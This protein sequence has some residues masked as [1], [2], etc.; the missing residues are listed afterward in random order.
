MDTSPS[1]DALGTSDGDC[2]HRV[3]CRAVLHGRRNVEPTSLLKEH[4]GASR[5]NE[6]GSQVVVSGWRR[7]TEGLICRF[8]PRE[9]PGS[10]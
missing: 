2:C 7:K 10:F 6:D 3:H 9:T 5:G 8:P 1:S 4:R